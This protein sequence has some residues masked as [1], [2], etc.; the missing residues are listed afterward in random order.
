MAEVA[1][2]RLHAF[3]LLREDGP[4]EAAQAVSCDRRDAQLTAD[5]LRA[6]TRAPRTSKE[7]P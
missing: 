4:I 7:Q 3:A 1:L 5:R 6:L 2:D